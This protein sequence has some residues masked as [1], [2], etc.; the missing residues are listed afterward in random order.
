[1]AVVLKVSLQYELELLTLHSEG[2][3]GA[4]IV[5]CFLPIDH[6]FVFN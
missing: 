5:W 4:K 6:Q 2:Q 1:M 3:K